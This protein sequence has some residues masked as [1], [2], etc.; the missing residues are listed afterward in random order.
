[1]TKINRKNAR[2]RINEML[3]GY[4]VKTCGY[5]NQSK[6]IEMTEA[7]YDAILENILSNCTKELQH[8]LARYSNK[9]NIAWLGD[10]YG[11]SIRTYD[12]Q[13]AYVKFI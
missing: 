7:E 3:N 12:H 11:G 4:E 8:Y 9:Y 5:K 2:E 1:M 6:Y 10:A 13:Y